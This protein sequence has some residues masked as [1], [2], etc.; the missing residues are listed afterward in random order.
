MSSRSG[1]QSPGFKPCEETP[2]LFK[3]GRYYHSMFYMQIPKCEDYLLGGNVCG[4]LWR[5][6]DEPSSWR[7]TYRYR[8]YNSPDPHDKRDKWSWYGLHIPESGKKP[9]DIV[10][11]FQGVIG[12]AARMSFRES[13]D[14][15]TGFDTVVIE[16]D[17]ERALE[18]LFAQRK[19]WLHFGSI[20]KANR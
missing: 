10:T 9:S 11:L 3:E 14:L 8:Y 20:E 1:E 16:G 12:Y 15:D 6:D 13:E 7:L 2:F 4:L 18:I 19:D 5:L 17:S